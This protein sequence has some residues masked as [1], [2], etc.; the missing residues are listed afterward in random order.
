MELP[1]TLSRYNAVSVELPEGCYDDL[2]EL[3]AG[4]CYM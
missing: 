1:W 4:E 2:P 3:L